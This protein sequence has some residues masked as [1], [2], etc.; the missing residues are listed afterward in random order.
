[1][2]TTGSQGSAWQDAT[3]TSA[4]GSSTNTGSSSA[5]GSGSGRSSAMA[6]NAS[7]TVDKIASGAHQAVDR[8]ASA[9]TSAASQF[10]V[11]GDEMLEAKDRML[12]S[13]R[14]YV[15][16]NPMAALGIALAAGFILSRIMR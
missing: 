4:T 9:A 1:M 11:K 5:S 7:A 10:G 6:D 13:T 8:I 15:R 2:A 3:S 12:E 16:D 14:E